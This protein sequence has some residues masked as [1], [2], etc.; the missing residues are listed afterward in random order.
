LGASLL[1]PLLSFSVAVLASARSALVDTFC[2]ARAISAIDGRRKKG[3]GPLRLCRLLASIKSVDENERD[4]GT[5][6]WNR[7]K[8]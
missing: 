8:T 6:G 3:D 5:E 2:L 1:S 7:I 4:I